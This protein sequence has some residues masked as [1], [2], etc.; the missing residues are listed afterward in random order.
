MEAGYTNRVFC[1]VAQ[2]IQ[3]NAGILSLETEV[4]HYYETYHHYKDVSSEAF[5]VTKYN[6]TLS[7]YQ[8]CLVVA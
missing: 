5:T 6:K 7:S 2:A 1:G 3:E 4:L 8:L